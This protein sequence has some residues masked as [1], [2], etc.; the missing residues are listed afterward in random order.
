MKRF[1]SFLLFSSSK[2]IWNKQKK[3]VEINS[4]IVN[5]ILQQKAKS[6]HLKFLS[7]NSTLLSKSPILT[8]IV[9]TV[10]FNIHLNGIS[11]FGKLFFII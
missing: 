4:S 2:S 9:D 11:I 7:N 3:T 1:F 6:G 5:S 10:Q 8:D